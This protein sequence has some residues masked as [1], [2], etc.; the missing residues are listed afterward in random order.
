MQNIPSL[1]KSRGEWPLGK[2]LIMNIKVK[3]LKG[4]R[5]KVVR[6]L[7]NASF[8]VII[9]Q[10]MNLKDGVGAVCSKCTIYTPVNTLGIVIILWYSSSTERTPWTSASLS[11]SNLTDFT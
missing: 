11:T 3:I 7:K 1:K 2:K 4:E 5:K 9:S 8:S 6:G 10:K